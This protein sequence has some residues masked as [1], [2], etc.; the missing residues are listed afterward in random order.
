MYT[1]SGQHTSTVVP[2]SRIF[3]PSLAGQP[4]C[5]PTWSARRK[6]DV[7]DRNRGDTLP[8]HSKSAVDIARVCA[9][10]RT[11]ASPRFRFIPFSD[12]QF[13]GCLIPKEQPAPRVAT[14]E[15]RI[16]NSRNT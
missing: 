8:S 11:F 10:R 14:L 9:K 13:G 16:S 7:A 12:R 4:R 1:V 5:W 2:C 3:V 6:R 15:Y